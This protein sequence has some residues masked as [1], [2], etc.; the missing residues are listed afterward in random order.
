[1]RHESAAAEGEG[2][3]DHAD[4]RV[5]PERDGHGRDVVDEALRPDDE[6]R[7]RDRGAEAGRDRERVDRS[8]TLPPSAISAMP[9]ADTANATS[10]IR[11]RL[12]GQ[13]DRREDGEEDR[14]RVDR[15]DRHRHRGELQGLEEERPVDRNEKPEAE[16]LVSPLDDGEQPHAPDEQH[17]H[18]NG[19]GRDHTAPEDERRGGEV[20]AGH[21]H[22]HEAPR[23]RQA[24]DEEIPAVEP[25]IRSG[26]STPT[27]S[28]LRAITVL[29]ASQSA[30]PEDLFLALED[31]VLVVEAVEVVGQPD[32]VDRQRMRSAALGRLGHYR[33]G[34]RRAA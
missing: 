10:P 1:M 16:Q 20:D 28:R 3:H 6:E 24:G 5:A 25:H 17:E 18:R 22:G 27:R 31:A 32:R 2:E 14:R 29:V 23:R 9:G 33:R 8:A 15:Q 19:D 11:L 34:I 13:E 7:V 12:S 4:E 21:D 30:R 26:A